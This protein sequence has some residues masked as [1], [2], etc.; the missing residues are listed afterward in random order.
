MQFYDDPYNM[1]REKPTT[2]KQQIFA[3]AIQIE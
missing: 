1:Q 3:K 2:T